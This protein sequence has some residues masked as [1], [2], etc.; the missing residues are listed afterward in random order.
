MVTGDCNDYKE[1]I[2]LYIINNINIS[3]SIFSL[4][5]AVLVWC[6]QHKHDKDTDTLLMNVVLLGET[7]I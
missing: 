4:T 2:L 1:E 7:F 3:V 5:L 6:D